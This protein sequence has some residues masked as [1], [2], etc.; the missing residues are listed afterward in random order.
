MRSNGRWVVGTLLAALLVG[1][2]A[3][4]EGDYVDSWIGNSGSGAPT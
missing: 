2:H 3:L 4:A 1:S